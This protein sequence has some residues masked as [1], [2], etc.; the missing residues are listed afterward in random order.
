MAVSEWSDQTLE[1]LQPE[2][3]G[4]AELVGPTP[5]QGDQGNQPLESRE[6]E[7]PTGGQDQ[8]V[9]VDEVEGSKV[10][11]EEF[12]KECEACNHFLSSNMF[13]HSHIIRYHKNLLR[14]CYMCLCQYMYPWDFNKHLDTKHRKCKKCQK[15]LWD[16][17]LLRDHMERDHPEGT[18]AQVE[19]ESQETR[20]P[21][22]KD[23]SHQDHQVKCKYCDRYFKSIAKSNMHINRKHKKVTCS[24]CE[25]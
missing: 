19:M 18:E 11:T 13:R 3:A 21:A 10:H 12:S 1:T 8:Q 17:D 2:D 25:K 9:E 16:D 14:H 20:D 23:T 6:P 4:T 24:E 5:E 22:I 15:Y 7:V